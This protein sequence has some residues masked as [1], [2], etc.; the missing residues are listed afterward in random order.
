MMMMMMMMM[1]MSFW[2]SLRLILFFIDWLLLSCM[3]SLIIRGG[4]K[5]GLF[6]SPV[7]DYTE[8][9]SIYE[10]VQF[11]I[12]A[13]NGDLHLTIFKYFSH[14][15]NE[16]I[17]DTRGLRSFNNSPVF[18]P[19]CN[20]SEAVYISVNNYRHCRTHCVKLYCCTKMYVYVRFYDFHA[21][22]ADTIMMWSDIDESNYQ[23]ARLRQS[24]YPVELGR[25]A[26]VLKHLLVWYT[27]IKYSLWCIAFWSGLF[28]TTYVVNFSMRRNF[29]APLHR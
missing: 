20:Y 27:H 28:C 5:S 16:T 12:W 2:P 29:S 1:M 10:T 14:N 6:I 21:T 7:Y 24:F 13:E 22:S 8:K 17:R 26:L 15:F 9:R 23:F 11:F 3:K 4:P 19:P 18:G 25:S